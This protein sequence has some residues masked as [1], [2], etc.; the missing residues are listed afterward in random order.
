MISIINEM[1]VCMHVCMYVTTHRLCEVLWFPLLERTDVAMLADGT[2]Y[3]PYGM[4]TAGRWLVTSWR[5]I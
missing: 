2:D 1:Y 5:W 4:G 3:L